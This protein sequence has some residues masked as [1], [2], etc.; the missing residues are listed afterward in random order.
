MRYL[1]CLALLFGTSFAHAGPFCQTAGYFGQVATLN[2]Y[3]GVPRF[4]VVMK[5]DGY[6]CMASIDKCDKRHAYLRAVV[7][8]VYDSLTVQHFNERQVMRY[9]T[10]VRKTTTSACNDAYRE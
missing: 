4:V 2:L 1:F 7:N 10:D 5:A 3:Y 9:A 8:L 6:R